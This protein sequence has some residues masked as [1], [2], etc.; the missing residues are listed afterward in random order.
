[1]LAKLKEQANT[2][3]A[4]G[5]EEQA[6]QLDHLVKTMAQMKVRLYRSFSPSDEF[7]IVSFVR[8]RHEPQQSSSKKMERRVYDRRSAFLPFGKS[9]HAK[10]CR[11]QPQRPKRPQRHHLWTSVVTAGSRNGR[12]SESVT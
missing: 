8:C 9:A 1:M 7:R 12:Q 6:N 3:R 11:R 5:N 2:L 10:P 4:D